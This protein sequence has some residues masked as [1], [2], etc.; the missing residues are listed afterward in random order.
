MIK[1]YLIYNT[2]RFIIVI[3]KILFFTSKHEKQKGSAL[4]Q[5]NG[6]RGILHQMNEGGHKKSKTVKERKC[7]TTNWNISNTVLRRK[8]GKKNQRGITKEFKR[9]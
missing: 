3:N 7:E 6:V 2:P 9:T 5:E 1:I 8:G 4:L